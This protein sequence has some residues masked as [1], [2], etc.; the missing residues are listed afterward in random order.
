VQFGYGRPRVAAQNIDS[1]AWRRA[2]R[3]G[4]DL[5][6]TIPSDD[7]ADG[8]RRNNIIRRDQSV[9]RHDCGRQ[10]AR[11]TVAYINANQTFSGAERVR[12]GRWGLDR[13]NHQ[14]DDECRFNEGRFQRAGHDRTNK[15]LNSAKTGEV[16]VG[17]AAVSGS[18]AEPV[19]GTVYSTTFNRQAL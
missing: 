17:T 8:W 15:Y 4:G 18:A 13:F 16:G 6:G 2:V 10:T 3:R 12:S 1:A 7:R 9:E 11:H 19:N 5:A 14:S